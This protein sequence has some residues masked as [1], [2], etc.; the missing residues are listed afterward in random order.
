MLLEEGIDNIIHRCHVQGDAVR[1]AAKAHGFELLNAAS[2]GDVLTPILMP[3]RVKASEVA[4]YCRG[5]WGIYF[6]A[7]QDDYKDKIVRIGHLG[8]QDHFETIMAIAAFEMAMKHF[9]LDIEL[10][11]GVKAAQEI[12]MADLEEQERKSAA[13]G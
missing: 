12:L 1:A 13:A 2:P 5:H 11:K 8:Y 4:K 6:A 9:G 3:E 7:G 10:G